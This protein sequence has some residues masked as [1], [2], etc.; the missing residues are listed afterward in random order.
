MKDVATQK[1]R[2]S[3]AVNETVRI[4]GKYVSTKSRLNGKR[5]HYDRR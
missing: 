2:G 4:A 1:D 5:D 3:I